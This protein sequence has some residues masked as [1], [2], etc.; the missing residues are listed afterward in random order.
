MYVPFILGRQGC[1][2]V[3]WT[4]LLDTTQLS[5]GSHVLG[6]V[7]TTVDG[8]NSTASA[9]FTVG[10]WMP[11]TPGGNAVRMDID[12]PGAQSGALSGTAHLGG[13]AID[14]NT[15][16]VSVQV[17]IDNVPYG[18]AIYGGSRPDVCQ[19][20]P[21]RPGCPNVGWDF[22]LDTTLLA[23]GSHTLSVTGVS[24]SGQSTTITA[25]FSIDNLASSGM[26]IYIDSPAV[27]ASALSGQAIV[28][29]WA[30]DNSA[31]IARIEVDIDGNSFG[32]ATYGVVRNDVCGV[33]PG[34]TGCPNVGW[35]ML[36]DTTQLSN[37]THT[38]NATAT[39]TSGQRATVTRSFS[40]SN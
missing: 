39:T 12:A 40:I 38:L 1:P 10:N 26:S 32:E 37:G 22:F 13:W 21:S 14:D 18:A 3:G 31:G 20:Y 11:S 30:L 6:V 17:T 19:A 9:S 29:G 34:R 23:E 8:R 24:F 28:G 25:K 36:L 7:A 15:S 35:Q 4:F 5:N 33:F 27:K 2:N 16:I